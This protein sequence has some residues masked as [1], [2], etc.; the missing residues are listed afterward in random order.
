MA[1][2]KKVAWCQ[3]LSSIQ[4]P[5]TLAWLFMVCKKKE[6]RTSNNYQMRVC[7]NDLWWTIPKSIL[8]GNAIKGPAIT[9]SIDLHCKNF[10][11]T[12]LSWEQRVTSGQCVNCTVRWPPTLKANAT[13]VKRVNLSSFCWLGPLILFKGQARNYAIWFR[14]DDNRLFWKRLQTAS[15]KHTPKA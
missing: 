1:W 10:T 12:A 3:S 15:W 5:I 11:V 8:L 9:F 7:H 13:C 2:N 4:S 14:L 6:L